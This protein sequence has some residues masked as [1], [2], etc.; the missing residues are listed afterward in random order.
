M[1]YKRR[2]KDLERRQRRRDPYARTLSNAKYRQRIVKNKTKKPSKYKLTVN[3]I[4][5][6]EEH[7]DD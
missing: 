5:N 6:D 4:L 1:G 3:N 7:Q 2:Q